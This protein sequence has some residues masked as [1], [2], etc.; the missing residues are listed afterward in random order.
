MR[1]MMLMKPHIE[2]EDNWTPTPEA[3]AAMSR[4]NEELR[5]AGVL[6]SLDG[7]HPSGRGARVSFADGTPTVTHGPFHDEELLGG[8]WM[9]EVKSL[10]EAIEW[11]T[12]CPASAREVIE[13]RQ[14]FEMADFPPEV[15]AAAAG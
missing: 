5:Q 6:L 7:L 3:V 13:V 2:N 10:E 15:Q 12:R 1:F 11:A 8:Y 4:Y 9:I 14:V